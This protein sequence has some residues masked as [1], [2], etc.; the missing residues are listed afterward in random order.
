MTDCLKCVELKKK[1]EAAAQKRKERS[2]ELKDPGTQFIALTKQ[3]DTILKKV[4]KQYDK[5]PPE[6]REQIE[7]LVREL[8]DNLTSD[9]TKNGSLSSRG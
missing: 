9:M 3:I 2:E 6:I 1:Q 5:A 8:T 4:R 7:E